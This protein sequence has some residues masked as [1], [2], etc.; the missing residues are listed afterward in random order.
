MSLGA[1][2][3]RE[4]S[5]GFEGHET[6]GTDKIPDTEFSAK[7]D[8]DGLKAKATFEGARPGA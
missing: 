6:G 3:S 5:T 7:D 4:W 1:R 8:K 2:W